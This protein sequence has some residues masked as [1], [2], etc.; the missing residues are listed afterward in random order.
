LEKLGGIYLEHN[1]TSIRVPDRC[2]APSGEG[3]MEKEYGRVRIL[4]HLTAHELGVLP[5]NEKRG[6]EENHRGIT[7]IWRARLL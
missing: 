7:S 3:E 6:L 5:G 1:A 4:S 2:K